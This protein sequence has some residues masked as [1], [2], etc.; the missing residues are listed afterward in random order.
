MVSENIW[1]NVG[2]GGGRVWTARERD[3]PWGT[4]STRPWL[5]TD[6]STNVEISQD[7][8]ALSGRS[9]PQKLQFCWFYGSLLLSCRGILE[10]QY[11]PT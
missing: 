1:C 6:L 7:R 4:S 2:V 3:N 9:F 8:P 5:S 10:L 11:Q